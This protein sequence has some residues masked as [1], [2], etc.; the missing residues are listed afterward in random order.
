M[1]RKILNLQ[2]VIDKIFN[3]EWVAVWPLDYL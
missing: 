1:L 2:I 3:D